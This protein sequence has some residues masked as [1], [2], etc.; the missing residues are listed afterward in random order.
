MWG[1]RVLTSLCKSEITI[2]DYGG[3]RSAFM[4]LWRSCIFLWGILR[5]LMRRSL[6]LCL[7]LSFGLRI[8]LLSFVKLD[9][10]LLLIL[11]SHFLTKSAFPCCILYVHLQREEHTCTHYVDTNIAYP[12]AFL[13]TQCLSLPTYQSYPLL[14]YAP[15]VLPAYKYRH[16]N[17][18]MDKQNRQSTNNGLSPC[19]MHERTSRLGHYT[20]IFWKAG[21]KV[22]FGLF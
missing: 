15:G 9:C 8:L 18:H 11:A 19:C 12:Q 22:E 2:G 17:K 20:Q 6:W 7:G 13:L 4:F 16:T 10:P 1:Q 14:T 21:R 3:K 5:T